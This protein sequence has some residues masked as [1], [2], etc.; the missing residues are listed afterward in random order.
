[1]ATGAELSYNTSATALQMAQSLFGGTTTVVGASY[2]GDARSSGT[3]ANGN[4]LS[5]GVVPGDSGVILSTGRVDSFTQSSGDPNRSVNTSYNSTG[6]DGVAAFNTLAGVQT[7]DA[8]YLDVDFIP[9]GNVLTMNLVFGSEEYPFLPGQSFNDVAGVWVNGTLVPIQAGD[10]KI[11]VS[12]INQ[13]TNSSLFKSNTNDA[14]NTEMDGFTVTLKLTVPVVA[15]QV[16]SIRIGIADATDTVYDSNVLVSGAQVSTLDALA[17]QTVLTKFASGTLNVLGNDLNTTGS[18]LTVTHING[19]AV[20]PGG[21]VT[22][23][24]GL[25]VTLN[26]D[27]TFTIQNDGDLGQSTF[28]YTV[29]NADGITDTAVVTIASVPCFV[30]GTLILTA[31]GEFPVERLQPGMMVMTRDDGPQ[32][33]RWI[34]RRRVKAE[35]AFAPVAIAAGT[36]GPHRALRVSPQHRLLI[37]GA[38]A[39][40]HFAEP[41]VLIPAKD[42]V[43]GKA[44][45]VI[46]GGHVE[47]VHL[48][49]DKHQVIWSEGLPTESFLPGPQTTNCIEDDL[50]REICALFPHLDPQTGKGY[51]RSARRV[52]RRHEAAVLTGGRA[53]SPSVEQV[54][55]KPSGPTAKASARGALPAA[56][57]RRGG[58]SRSMAPGVGAR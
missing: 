24:N 50:V 42:M 34:G 46:E 13:S 39:E 22:L 40:L 52:L 5:P 33:L 4:A 1:M 29:K 11:S 23:A 6:P 14:Y 21:S 26:A 48:L 38:L 47:Y 54:V 55:G 37:E 58:A 17:D 57:D 25:V 9:T 27:G 12:N 28:S 36:F 2:T 51:S 30:A 15:G 44:V 7:F 45:R 35:G 56:R 49:F 19:I 53:A 3:Y 20:A 8:S 43:D 31:R 18:A 41:E 16:N 32:P 10:G